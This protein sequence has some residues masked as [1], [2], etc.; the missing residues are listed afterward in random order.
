MRTADLPVIEL[1]G[2][3]HQRG[4]IHGES[5]KSNIAEVVEHWLSDLGNYG[6]KQS[7]TTQWDIDTYLDGLVADTQYLQTIE[8]TTPHLLEELQG[9]AEASGQPFKHIL[10][11]NLMDEEWVYGLR[12]SLSKPTHKCTAFATPHQANG[13]S[14]AGQNMDI[15]SWSEGHQVLFRHKETEGK[16]EALIFAIAGSIGL[17]G[18]NASGL[19]VTCNTLSQLEFATD[20]LPVAFIVR[21]LMEQHDIDAAAALLKNLRHASGQNYILSSS[22]RALCFECSGTGVTAYA[23][24]SLEGRLFHT[25]HPLISTDMSELKALANTPTTN[26][27]ARLN[28]ITQR[29]G[30]VE[31]LVTLENIK[32]ALSAHDNPSH[33]VSRKTN[34]TGS[35]IG[36]TAGSVIYEF[37][38]QLKLHLASGPPCET[39]Y[40]PFNF[41]REKKSVSDSGGSQ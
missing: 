39:D 4:L 10:G 2:S 19:G 24:G 7:G 34:K 35:S 6:S 13:V 30:N 26:S 27:Q 1:E 33:P 22:G 3:P 9:I 23:P 31:D 14:Y 11:L 28:S 20:G 38:P 18:L 21:L 41:S 32:A 16:P 29:L 17:I 25:N 8:Q 40:K 12:Q 5:L 37:S 36:Y 15:C